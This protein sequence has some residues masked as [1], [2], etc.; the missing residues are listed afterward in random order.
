MSPV[1]MVRFVIGRIS[2]IVLGGRWYD[3]IVLY[4]HAPPEE[5]GDNSKTDSMRNYKECSFFLCTVYKFFCNTL[6][7][8][9]EIEY[10]SNRELGMKVYMTIVKV[11]VLE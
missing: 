4:E 2:Y 3:T 11:M 7:Q 1:K 9:G 6:I 5:N 10:F 8:T